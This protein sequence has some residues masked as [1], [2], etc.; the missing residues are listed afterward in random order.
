MLRGRSSVV[1]GGPTAAQTLLQDQHILTMFL[2][3]LR[4][5]LHVLGTH[6]HARTHT[7]NI[8]FVQEIIFVC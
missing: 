8:K 2:Q 5:G 6:A 4:V 3:T 1:A 7:M